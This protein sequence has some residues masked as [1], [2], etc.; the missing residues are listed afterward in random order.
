MAYSDRCRACD[1][2][3]AA[4][5]EHFDPTRSITGQLR[6][7]AICRHHFLPVG[8]RTAA[9]QLRRPLAKRLCPCC[10]NSRWARAASISAARF[11]PA[12]HDRATPRSNR[13]GPIAHRA[14]GPATPAPATSNPASSNCGPRRS[15]NSGLGALIAAD[16]SRRVERRRGAIRRARDDLASRICSPPAQ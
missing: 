2:G 14:P 12:R 5:L 3:R 8:I 16:C 9:Q 7:L 6:R 1:N 4:F 10:L 11:R 15:P 13:C